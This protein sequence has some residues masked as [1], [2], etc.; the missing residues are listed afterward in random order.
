M[1][2]TF[3][4]LTTQA[5]EVERIPLETGALFI[6]SDTKRS[7]PEIPLIIHLHGSEEV[8]KRNILQVKPDA[9]WVNIT[10]PGLS[11]IYGKHFREPRAFP[12]LLQEVKEALELRFPAKNVEIRPVTLV[13]FSAGF[14]GVRE[15][16]KQP[17]AIA[18]I[19][20]VIMADSLYAGFVGNTA[21]RE[22]NADHMKPFVQ[23]A[24]LAAKG[25]K[26]MLLT[27]SQLF[28]PGYAS[29]AE[30]AA[31]LIQS[32]D[33]QRLAKKTLRDQKLTE[34]SRFQRGQ[35]TVIEYDG[36]TGE[37]HLN[38]LRFIR[39]FLDEVL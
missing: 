31:Y 23:F 38:H 5:Q 22:L 11:S 33:G 35:F 6:A 30:T 14:G 18:H 29:T 3:L 13:S 28:T 39:L 7:G 27:H 4:L 15:L 37:D 9:I 36:D 17:E 8:V 25:Q 32:L 2:L 21:H 19:S 1:G 16:L 20:S 26:Q 10:L 12:T 34:L 24:E